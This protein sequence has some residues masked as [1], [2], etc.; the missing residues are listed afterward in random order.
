MCAVKFIELG[1]RHIFFQK[2]KHFEVNGISCLSVSERMS[3]RCHSPAV[4]AR[5]LVSQAACVARTEDCADFSPLYNILLESYSNFMSQ[6]A[7]AHA[8]KRGGGSGGGSGSV[9]CGGRSRHQRP[10]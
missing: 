8:T 5:K 10:G 6:S 2:H 9:C 7:L 4:M 1:R 3:K